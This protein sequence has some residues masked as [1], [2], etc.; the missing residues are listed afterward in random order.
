M[1]K[2]VLIDFAKKEKNCTVEELYE[3]FKTLKKKDV[4]EKAIFLKLSQDNRIKTTNSVVMLSNTTGLISIH[5]EYF[6]IDD[7]EPIFCGNVVYENGLPMEKTKRLFGLNAIKT[8]IDTISGDEDFNFAPPQHHFESVSST[9]KF[10]STC[11]LTLYNGNTS[12]QNINEELRLIVTKECNQGKSKEE[13]T[14]TRLNFCFILVKAYFN[15]Y[16]SKKDNLT[17]AKHPHNFL[18]EGLWKMNGN[19]RVNWPNKKNEFIIKAQAAI[20]DE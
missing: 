5:E 2:Y 20:S 10:I 8:F 4:L 14:N 12:E 7:G 17:Y 3:T 19:E 13:N 1:S 16:V 15:Y 6:I 11:I 18:R 9:I